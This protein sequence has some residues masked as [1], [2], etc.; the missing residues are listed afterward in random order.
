[1]SRADPHCLAKWGTEQRVGLVQIWPSKDVSRKSLPHI[2]EVS[3]RAWTCLLEDA[4][5]RPACYPMVRIHNEVIR[6]D[7][8]RTAAPVDTATTNY[9]NRFGCQF[10]VAV[11]RALALSV[12]FSGTTTP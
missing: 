4:Q 5:R 8:Q 3:A 12:S 1:M 6:T 7:S 2:T 10:R 9:G 11:W